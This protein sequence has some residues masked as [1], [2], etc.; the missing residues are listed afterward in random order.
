MESLMNS[1]LHAYKKGSKEDD[2]LIKLSEVRMRGRKR[3]M[4][5]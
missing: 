1:V 4:I 3:D 5:G 2:V